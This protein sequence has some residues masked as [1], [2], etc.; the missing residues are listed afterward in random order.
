MTCQL[1][2]YIV[3]IL[4]RMKELMSKQGVF[5]SDNKNSILIIVA[6]TPGG[7]GG[8]AFLRTETRKPPI[9]CLLAECCWLVKDTGGPLPHLRREG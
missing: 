4:S 8:G 9:A 7:G 1:G 5:F 2:G 6:L 3:D